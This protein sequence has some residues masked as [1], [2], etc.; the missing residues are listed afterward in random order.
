MLMDGCVDG[1]L[2]RW[3]FERL[4][5]GLF[6]GWQLSSIPDQFAVPDVDVLSENMFF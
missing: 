6:S 1:W 5:G 4:F 3:I 2:F